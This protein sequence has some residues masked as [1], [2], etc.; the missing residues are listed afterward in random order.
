MSTESTKHVA[1]DAR[2][3]CSM[4]KDIDRDATP[5]SNPTR[6]KRLE[7]SE[8]IERAL[9]IAPTRSDRTLRR[10]VVVLVALVVMC[11]VMAAIVWWRLLT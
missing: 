11:L 9:R 5:P 8:D 4:S 10:V 2:P 7:T 6:A 1:Q 3:Q